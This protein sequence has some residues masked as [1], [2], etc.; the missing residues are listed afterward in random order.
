MNQAKQKF[1]VMDEDRV[2]SIESTFK[3]VGEVVGEFN[4][5]N[6]SIKVVDELKIQGFTVQLE[7][8]EFEPDDPA[9]MKIP[10]TTWDN[11]FISK[12]A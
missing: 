3:G 11:G 4:P 9:W 2:R 8:G 10:P 5:N 1:F 7:R 12:D 6:Y